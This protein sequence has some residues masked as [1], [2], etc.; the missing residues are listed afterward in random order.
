MVDS[1]LILDLFLVAVAVLSPWSL[2]F[3]HAGLRSATA[4]PGV[5]RFLFLAMASVFS[6]AFS[7]GFTGLA[8]VGAEEFFA[9][10]GLAA[11][12]DLA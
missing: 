6:I 8:A 2:R 1:S 4:N 12:E 7:I 10:G 3:D 9:M 11:M 5:K